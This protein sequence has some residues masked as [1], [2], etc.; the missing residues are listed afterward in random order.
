M[1]MVGGEQ[2]GGF[3]PCVSVSMWYSALWQELGE[4]NDESINNI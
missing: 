4:T 2:G 3:T 1:E